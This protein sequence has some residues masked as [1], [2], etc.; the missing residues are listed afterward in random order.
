MTL[1]RAPG[2][3]NDRATSCSTPSTAAATRPTPRSTRSCPPAWWCRKTMDEA[4][5]A[6]AIARDEGVNV[7]P[8]GGGTS[9]CGQTVNRRPRR[10]FLQAPEPHPLA[11]RREPHLRGRARHRARRPQPPAQEAWPVVSGR[12]LHRLARHHRRHGRQQFLR[13][14]LA[15]LRHHARQHAVDGGRAGRRHA[16][17]FRRGPARSRRLDASDSARA[18]FRDM[19]DLGAREADEIAARFPKV[20]RRVGGYNLDALGAA[21]C[22]ATT[23]RIC[24]SARKARSP[25][26]PRSS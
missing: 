14:P 7:T 26:P 24:W 11:R 5:R 8:R 22:A 10:R 19:L 12:R 18:L 6:L 1:E 15:A 2:A 4:L 13:R 3:R 9:Q 25:S 16:A 23:W 21:Q 17:A 20:Q